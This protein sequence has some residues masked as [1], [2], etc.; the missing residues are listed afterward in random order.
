M[1]SFSDLI[2][3]FQK[4]QKRYSQ[5]WINRELS[6]FIRQGVGYKQL[7]FAAG[8]LSDDEAVERMLAFLKEAITAS[9]QP[10]GFSFYLI[11]ISAVQSSAIGSGIFRGPAEDFLP[12]FDRKSFHT[13]SIQASIRERVRMLNRDQGKEIVVAFNSAGDLITAHYDATH[14]SHV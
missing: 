14:A 6:P 7:N 9:R 4:W 11:S 10:Y 8:E 5:W 2:K 3:P 12:P 13:G 1:I